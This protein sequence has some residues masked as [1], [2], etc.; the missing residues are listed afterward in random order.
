VQSYNFLTQSPNFLHIIFSVLHTK[1]IKCMFLSVLQKWQSLVFACSLTDFM[2]TDYSLTDYFQT[3]D[4]S[5]RHGYFFS[6]KELSAVV[7][8]RD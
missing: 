4:S 7:S 2:T 8:R 1:A 3:T 6:R 5:D